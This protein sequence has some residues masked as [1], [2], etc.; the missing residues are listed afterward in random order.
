MA[1]ITFD[2]VIQPWIACMK[3]LLLVR[4]N[5]LRQVEEICLNP[6][7]IFDAADRSTANCEFMSRKTF[8]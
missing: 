8:K 7:I 4:W 2:V 1:Y 3:I 6:Q 5:S